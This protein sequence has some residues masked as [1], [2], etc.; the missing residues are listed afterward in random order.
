M[1][2]DKDKLRI[3]RETPADYDEVYELVNM[4]FATSSHFDG[5]EADYLNALRKK[6]VFIPELALVAVSEQ[7]GEIIGQITLYKTEIQTPQAVL[8]E[9]L[10]S[11]IC[12]HPR[13]FRRGIARAMVEEALGLAA[14]MGYRAVFL[15]GE[16]EIYKR[17]GFK[18]TFSY[19]IFHADDPAAEW[20][21]VRE[22]YENALSGITGTIRTL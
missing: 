12:V 19:N 21:M 16:P 3:R 15:C 17:L 8:T 4:S 1:T 2:E 5:T 18:P 9:L 7:N 13:Y 6:D 14:D 10:L 20:S 11:P 22:L